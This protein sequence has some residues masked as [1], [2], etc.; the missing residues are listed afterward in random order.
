MLLFTKIF[1]AVLKS[2]FDGRDGDYDDG[3]VNYND[4]D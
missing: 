1:A 4:Y 3:G 2:D